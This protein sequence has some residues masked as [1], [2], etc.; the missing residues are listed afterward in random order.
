MVGNHIQVE[1]VVALDTSPKVA[2]LAV[3][4]SPEVPF[5]KEHLTSDST[6]DIHLL[7]SSMAIS[8]VQVGWAIPWATEEDVWG[9]TG[10][11]F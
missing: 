10:H 3:V 7:G 6:E 4:D 9:R 2:V 1:V 5:L 11:H 8:R